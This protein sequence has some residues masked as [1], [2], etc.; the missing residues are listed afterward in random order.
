MKLPETERVRRDRPPRSSL[1]GERQRGFTLIETLLVVGVVAILVSTVAISVRV[2]V[3]GLMSRGSAQA[4]AMDERTIQAASS[5]FHADVHC[6]DFTDGW[7]EANCTTGHYFPTH[8]GECS[9]LRHREMVGLNAETTWELWNGNGTRATADDVKAAAIRMGLLVPEPGDSSSDQEVAPSD[10]RSL[11]CGPAGQ[12]VAPGDG[13]SQGDGQPG[14]YLNEV[15]ESCSQFNSSEGCGSYTWIVGASGR[16]Y[17]AFEEDNVWYA[18]FS[19][20]YP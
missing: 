12:D 15:P 19:G 5:A 6:F 17:C 9:D 7:N 20:G 18:G 16:V 3:G 2:S 1:P 11:V 4:C 8:D 10:G 13:G 14:L